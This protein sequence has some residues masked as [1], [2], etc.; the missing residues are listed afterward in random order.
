MFAFASTAAPAAL[1]LPIRIELPD[2]APLELGPEPR[3][4]LRVLDPALLAGTQRPGLDE[5]AEAY[6]ER[7]IEIDGPIQDVIEV[8]AGLSRIL[9]ASGVA[10]GSPGRVRPAHAREQDAEDISYH[11]DLSNDFYRLWLDPEMVYSCAYFPTGREGLAEAQLA[12]L[13]LVCRKLRLQPGHYLLDVGCGWG[14][15]ARLAAR[16][17]GV[18]VL[19]ITLSREQLRLARARVRAEKLQDRVQLEL[20]DY[21][22]L[23]RDG[24]FDRIASIGMVEHVG[25]AN[26]PA[27]CR[28]LHD[29]LRPGGLLL[30]H[31]ITATHTDPARQQGSEGA[32]FIHRYVFPHGEVPHLALVVAG[33]S[34][35]G[36]EVADVENLRPHYAR[37]LACWSQSLERHLVQARRL[38]PEKTLRI[39]RLYLA[40]CAWAFRQGRVQIHQ[41]LATRPRGDGGQEL[42]WS[43]GD[44]YEKS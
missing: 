20:M 5:L 38:V 22:D 8:A 25:H 1:G 14:A 30:N 23:P 43:R 12:K 27:Y 4:T 44:V 17:F 41:V 37:T 11:Y 6:V 16:E 10:E 21:R 36:L 28:G 15:L 29:A 3:V 19:G 24:R 26:L 2:G 31:G 18:R 39:W 34:D 32:R 35:A 40:G 33:L 7:R 42:P 9:A 13:R